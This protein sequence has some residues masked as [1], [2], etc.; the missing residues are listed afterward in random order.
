MSNRTLI[1]TDNSPENRNFSKFEKCHV[2]GVA[3][4]KKS[5]FQSSKDY[6][7]IFDF[8]ILK[9]RRECRTNLQIEKIYNI[10]VKRSFRIS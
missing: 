7:K 6:T 4:F 10:D 8:V 1:L 9:T 3:E 5:N 2:L